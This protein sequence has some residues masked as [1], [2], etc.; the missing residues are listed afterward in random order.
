[1]STI[2]HRLSAL[3]TEMQGHQLD[4]YYVPSIDQHNN[5]Y[6][7]ACWQRRSF[8]T[9]F[10][11][12]AGD[13][14]IGLESAYLWTDGRYFLQAEQQ[15]TGTGVG[16]M[17]QLQGVAPI[18]QWLVEN[19][20]GCKVGVDPRVI[21]LKQ[22]V[23]W[24][25]SLAQVDG[26]LVSVNHNLIDQ[27]W[28]DQPE[29]TTY[30][31]HILDQRYSGESFTQKLQRL[32]KALTEQHAD[33]HV[34]TQL[35]DIAWL[36]NIRGQ[37][38]AFNPLALSYAVVTQEQTILALDLN[39]LTNEDRTYF[40]ENDVNLVEYNEFSQILN[41]LSGSVSLDPN[42]ASWWIAQQLTEANLMF[43]PS[44]IT[45][46]KACKNET[47]QQGMHEAHRQDA[48]AMCQFIHWLEQNWRGQTELSA[49]HKLNEMRRK[50][51]N[52]RD[53]SFTT[54]SGYGP[55]GA[56]IH[57]NV[58]EDTDIPLNNDA[59]YLVDSGGQYLSGTTDITR[60][61]HFGEPTEQEKHHYNISTKGSPSPWACPVSRAHVWRTPRRTGSPTTVAR[62]LKLCSRYWTRCWLLSLCS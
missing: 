59:L 10:T 22:V 32:R 31:I 44:P 52:C 34:L 6:V 23:R 55:H 27:I 42:T 17:K 37:D 47:E 21:S 2:P 48:L 54:I 28:A 13:A 56:I 24:E 12:S 41:H 20:P 30:P 61:L 29:L 11:G 26:E 50:N 19:Q 46:M 36:F 1:M 16:L 53:L 51:D 25:D 62:G 43:A 7:P 40:A 4:F 3:R 5:E 35:D 8:I 14:L 15:L 18:D 57:Y 49:A 9:G 39:I 60:T 58:T 38:V 45:L 33:A